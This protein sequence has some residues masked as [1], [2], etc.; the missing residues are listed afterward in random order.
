MTYVY[1]LQS[2]DYPEQRYVGMTQDLRLRMATHNAGG[3]SHTAKYKPW[4]L[5]TYISFQDRARAAVFEQYLKSG[6]G[7][8]FANKHFGER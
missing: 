4:R 1:L 2:I 6:S 7:R 5:V 8:A 3:S